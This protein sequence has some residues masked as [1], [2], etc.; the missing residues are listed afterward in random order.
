MGGRVIVIV[1]IYI[2]TIQW[3]WRWAV[4]G[5]QEDEVLEDMTVQA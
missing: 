2:D 4:E 1:G 3:W 5:L